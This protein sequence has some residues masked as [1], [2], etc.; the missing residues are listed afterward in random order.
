MILSKIKGGAEEIFS[1]PLNLIFNVFYSQ[2]LLLCPSP[3]NPLRP[4][5]SEILG[6]LGGA[7]GNSP[8]SEAPSPLVCPNS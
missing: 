1:V 3:T 7:G 2:A 5:V 4:G 8:L 6:G